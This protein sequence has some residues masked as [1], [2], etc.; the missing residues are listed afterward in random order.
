[1]LVDPRGGESSFENVVTAMD[2]SALSDKGKLQM[3]KVH[4]FGVDWEVGAH[5]SDAAIDEED[6]GI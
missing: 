5:I 2:K 6:W 1:M 4:R 3:Y